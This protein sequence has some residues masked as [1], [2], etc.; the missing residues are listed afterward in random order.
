MMKAAPDLGEPPGFRHRRARR[1]NWRDPRRDAPRR[2]RGDRTGPGPESR[3]ADGD[4]NRSEDFA[5]RGHGLLLPL[6]AIGHVKPADSR[7]ERG[8][9]GHPIEYLLRPWRH[10]ESPLRRSAIAGRAISEGRALIE[11]RRKR[12]ANGTAWSRKMLQREAG[13]SPITV[14]RALSQPDLV[15]PE[16]RARVAA[17]VEKTGYVV[18]SLASSLR[19]GRSPIIAV[20]V[21]NFFN[22]LFA[23]AMQGCARCAGGQRLSYDA[24]NR[25]HRGNW[26]TPWSNR[27]CHSVPRP[28]FGDRVQSPETRAVCGLGVPVVETWSCRARSDRHSGERCPRLRSGG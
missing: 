27:C 10:W 7:R 18:N 6:A 3:K 24:G 26:S 9:G 1:N 22:Q 4:C 20:F 23:A 13:V 25:G 16:T 17:A 28:F 12:S 21:S 19:S 8:V 14:S 11:K 15:R 2:C 5:G